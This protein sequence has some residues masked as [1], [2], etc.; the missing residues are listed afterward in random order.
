MK[1]LRCLLPAVAAIFALSVHPAFAK[2]P[3]SA[4]ADPEAVRSAALSPDGARMAYLSRIGGDDYLVLHDFRTQGEDVQIVQVS[5]LRTRDIAFVDANHVL[6]YT[7]A[8]S[9]S[10]RFIGR[11][12]KL[13]VS[14]VNLTTRKV[15]TLLG[16]ADNIYAGQANLANIAA[17]DPDGQNVYMAIYTGITGDT[18]T[19]D[20]LKVNLDTGASVR[21]QTLYRRR[22]AQAVD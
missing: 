13:M 9:N 7:S 16:K 1:L 14:S 2:P 3:V 11:D 18:P 8:M 19:Y 15:V 20:V 6:I 22:P 10:A 12:E 21:G 5:G 4:F 17:V